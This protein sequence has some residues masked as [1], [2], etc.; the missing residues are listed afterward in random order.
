MLQQWRK[1]RRRRHII[2]E[3]SWRWW[4]LHLKGN[5]KNLWWNFPLSFFF[6][7]A[8]KWCLLCVGRRDAWPLSGI[9]IVKLK[10]YFNF[11]LS[12]GA[13]FCIIFTVTA[14]FNECRVT[15]GGRRNRIHQLRVEFM[16]VLAQRSVSDERW[17]ELR[18]FTVLLVWSLESLHSRIVEILRMDGKTERNF[19]RNFFSQQ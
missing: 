1:E 2:F 17:G 15:N 11:F 6:S 19:T 4:N 12:L 10:N 3:E 14:F 5:G 9:I 18:R 16:C 8:A 13:T 7:V